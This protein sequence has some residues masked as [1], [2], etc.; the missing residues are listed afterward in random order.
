M[1]DTK[2]RTRAATRL[3]ATAARNSIRL[4]L[5][6][7]SSE[8]DEISFHPRYEG[9]VSILNDTILDTAP[10][11]NE[12]VAARVGVLESNVVHVKTQVSNMDAKLDLILNSALFGPGASS[13]PPPRLT[14][15]VTPPPRKTGRRAEPPTPYAL[16]APRGLREQ[17]NRAGFVDDM[18]SREKFV[19]IPTE[20]KTNLAF[21]VY[22]NTLMPKPYMYV[23]REGAQTVKQ[24]LDIRSTLTYHEYMNAL[25][26]L[27]TDSRAFHPEERDHIMAHILDV[28]RDAM[29]RPWD[30]VRKWSQYI[31][32]EVE[33]G[34]LTWRDRQSI[35]NH[36]CMMAIPS[37][38][39]P[40]VHEGR[41]TS[42]RDCICRAYN[43]RGGCRHRSHHEEGQVRLMHICSFCDSVG[44]Q[45][46][47]HNVIECDSKLRGPN[48]RPSF[49]PPQYNQIQTAQAR[50]MMS[51]LPWRGGNNF[52]QFQHFQQQSKNGQ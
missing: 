44:R 40:L 14:R 7:T 26:A 6:E 34:N 39:P 10:S 4:S 3:A 11:Q 16:P 48:Q 24:K 21:D 35:H 2:G 31:W 43:S 23:T 28:S 49:N 19:H 17:E 37:S 27:I 20:G 51:D 30:T 36:R 5:A 25:L 45:C 41:Q 47:G 38:R 15:Q 1:A 32:D 33:K 18:L 29:D 22:S 13:T 52:N 9:E 46:T 8:G 12:S 42:K 50:P